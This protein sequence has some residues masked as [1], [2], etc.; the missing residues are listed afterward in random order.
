RRWSARTLLDVARE[1]FRFDLAREGTRLRERADSLRE[2]L[3]RGPLDRM[4]TAAASGVSQE[5][6]DLKGRRHTLR[7]E[8]RTVRSQ[9]LEQRQLAESLEHRIHSASDV[10]RLKRDGIGRLDNIECPT[11]H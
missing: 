3:A 7:E 10:L 8:L 5:A 1:E 2:M 4:D 11:C 9:A 6:I